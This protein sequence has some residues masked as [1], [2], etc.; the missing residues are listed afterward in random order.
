MRLN[1]TGSTLMAVIV[2][3]LVIGGLSAVIMQQAS[4]SQQYSRLA[5]VKSAMFNAEAQIR[6]LAME[7]SSYIGCDGRAPETCR[8]NSQLLSNFQSKVAG[9]K[10][11]G[12]GSCGIVVVP[13]SATFDGTT[14]QFNAR[15]H[16]QGQEL[17]LRDIEIQ[18]LVIPHETLARAAALCPDA[19]PLFKG[20][21]DGV[22]MC[23]PLNAACP[24]N[25]WATKV[26]VDT[27]AVTCV[28]LPASLS[29]APGE[30]LATLTYDDTGIHR[31][32]RPR[33]DVFTF[34]NFTPGLTQR[35]TATT[36]TRT[37][38]PPSGPRNIYQVDNGCTVA[39]ADCEARAGAGNCTASTE[40]VYRAVSGSGGTS[41]VG[42][43]CDIAWPGDLRGLSCDPIG[44]TKSVWEDCKYDRYGAVNWDY[45]YL[46]TNY[47][48]QV[49]QYCPPVSTTTTTVPAGS[50]S[51]SCTSADSECSPGPAW[52]CSY[53]N[54]LTATGQPDQRGQNCPTE[55]ARYSFHRTDLG[56]CDPGWLDCDCGTPPTSTVTTT[57]RA[58]T[59]TTTTTLPPP[60]TTVPGAC[61]WQQV[62][63]NPGG[64]GA[65]GGGG[66]G[67]VCAGNGINGGGYGASA[68]GQVLPCDA[69]HPQNVGLT[70]QEGYG[71]RLD[72]P[73]SCD[74]TDY[75]CVCPPPTTTTTVVPR[76]TASCPSG[77]TFQFEKVDAG[78]ATT[79]A[80]CNILS[81]SA[82]DGA[83]SVQTPSNEY[84]A[85]RVRCV[86]S[87]SGS[88][89][90]NGRIS[91]DI[92]AQYSFYRCQAT[93][94]TTTTTQVG[95]CRM[96]PKIDENGGGQST[97]CWT[98]VNTPNIPVGT[99]NDYMLWATTGFC[100][101]NPSVSS[102]MQ[103]YRCNVAGQAPEMVYNGCDPAAMGCS[104]YMP[105]NPWGTAFYSASDYKGSGTLSVCNANKAR[106][107][108]GA[109]WRC[110]PA[111][112]PYG[113]P[114]P[115]CYILVN[116][117]RGNPVWSDTAPYCDAAWDDTP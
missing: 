29:C 40:G 58:T 13:G 39:L 82:V 27:L 114:P 61:G 76:V 49:F 42:R 99:A 102:C 44:S 116:S 53:S 113:P 32:C 67:T 15:I 86:D 77:S 22:A 7:P 17:P 47:E 69:A 79:D 72:G 78:S 35:S 88:C 75:E 93:T 24:P 101:N 34:N 81:C 97:N 36:S 115:N 51:W 3:S 84:A 31:T 90:P 19:A 45:P 104:C 105:W 41:Y 63:W 10:C 9:A 28:P 18:N 91:P 8:F 111:N 33:A 26:N 64:C 74:T 48:C 60:P 23:D 52:G 20:F 43:M 65:Q 6:S 46:L 108:L 71:E 30:Y 110:E 11:D 16:Y 57:T 4:Q 83:S 100:T 14:R 107:G 85:S 38:L 94:T 59:T 92:G 1:Q 70:Y 68:C 12:G 80:D 66:G 109:S 62:N 73:P 5:R 37:T 112:D 25:Q 56:T 2:T 98:Y 117:G 55:S 21:R 54:F 96:P 103:T 87:T 106:M 89:Q 95:S 50:C